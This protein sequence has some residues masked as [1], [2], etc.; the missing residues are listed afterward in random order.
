MLDRGALQKRDIF[1]VAQLSEFNAIGQSFGSS[2]LALVDGARVLFFVSPIS[3][4]GTHGSYARL[5]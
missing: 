5:L 4:T 1:C 3:S 2:V